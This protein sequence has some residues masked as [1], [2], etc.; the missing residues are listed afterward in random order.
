[1]LIEFLAIVIYTKEIHQKA[2]TVH[3][4]Q[5]LYKNL[6][7]RPEIE[8]RNSGDHKLRNHEMRG[9]PVAFGSWGRKTQIIPEQT[10]QKHDGMM[11]KTL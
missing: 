1:M 6:K 4:Q 10:L 11:S 2:I 3:K 8:S 7:K 9:F 5:T